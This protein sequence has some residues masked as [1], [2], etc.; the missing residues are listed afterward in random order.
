MEPNSQ[1]QQQQ[2]QV[3]NVPNTGMQHPMFSHLDSERQVSFVRKHDA[4]VTA[5]P[6]YRVAV[7]RYRDLGKPN[8]AVKPA[9]MVILPQVTLPEEYMLCD[10]ARQ[11]LIGVLEDQ[12]DVIIRQKIDENAKEIK[13][14]DVSVDSC[15][16]AL[17]ATRVSSRL[18]KEA[19]EAWVSVAMLPMLTERGKEI[20]KAKEMNAENTAKQVAS[21]INAYK[22]QYGKL[23]AAVPNIGKETAERLSQFLDKT[24]LSD[25][26]AKALAK[27]L[28][29]ILN[30]PALNDGDL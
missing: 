13:W 24:E 18:T 17:T 26:I 4:K 11:V 27:K 1:Q 25:D 15:L 29:A 6:E 10:K 7:I 19:I 30:P 28:K 14:A 20:A 16:D 21:T 2:P 12:Q 5:G 9:Q 8:V 3:P 23:A 22:E